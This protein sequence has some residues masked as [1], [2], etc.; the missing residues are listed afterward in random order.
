MQIYKAHEKK[1]VTRRLMLKTAPSYLHS[2]GQNTWTWRTDRQTDRRLV[3]LQRSALRAM[4]TC[5]KND[6]SRRCTK[7]SQRYFGARWRH[8]GKWQYSRCPLRH[9]SVRSRDSL[10][11]SLSLTTWPAACHGCAL[12]DY[13]GGVASSRAMFDDCVW[14]WSDALH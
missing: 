10:S 3:L 11:L 14:I 9:R 4:R 13:T 1:T 7:S 8:V 12:Y 6:I 5:C 2:S